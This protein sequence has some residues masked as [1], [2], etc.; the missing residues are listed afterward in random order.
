MYDTSA[1][2]L[3]Y[4]SYWLSIPAVFTLK[5]IIGRIIFVFGGNKERKDGTL[6]FVYVVIFS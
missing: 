4:I 5:D 1:H 6:N 3:E 2:V